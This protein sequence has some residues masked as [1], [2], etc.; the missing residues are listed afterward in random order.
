MIEYP[1]HTALA[2]QLKNHIAQNK[3]AH[4]IVING[5]K[6]MGKTA[7]AQSLASDIFND[8]L[9]HLIKI[10]EHPDLY[11]LQPDTDSETIK[12]QAIRTLIYS[13]QQTSNN[14]S[15]NPR[16]KFCYNK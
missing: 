7:F 12:V 1:W 5:N 15:V 9:S 8:N 4:G 6:G 10:N 3:L 2:N 16:A 11:H 14:N 13:L